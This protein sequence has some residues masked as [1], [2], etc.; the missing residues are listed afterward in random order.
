MNL[1]DSVSQSTISTASGFTRSFL[2]R[3]IIG[4]DKKSDPK[5]K[6]GGAK[7]PVGL[8]TLYE[9]EG[10][11]NVDLIFVHG[12]NGGSQST[13]SKGPGPSFWPRDWL[14]RDDAFRDVRIHSFGYSSAISRESILNIDDFANNLLACVHHLPVMT[15]KKE[16]VCTSD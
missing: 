12:L 13:W 16:A 7:G 9:P 8:T 3:S 10:H 11:T 5:D 1:S 6:Q 14:P 15:S 4:S 2:V